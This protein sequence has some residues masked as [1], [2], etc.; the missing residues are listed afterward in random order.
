M[1]SFLFMQLP[2]FYVRTLPQVEPV[3]RFFMCRLLNIYSYS[4]ST[5][6]FLQ[7]PG[8][9]LVFMQRRSSFRLDLVGVLMIKVRRRPHQAGT[10]FQ[11]L[12]NAVGIKEY[13]TVVMEFQLSDMGS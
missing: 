5:L 4:R 12:T 6:I 1:V 3:N 10:C 13:G 11:V 8:R 2:T 9:K 7:L